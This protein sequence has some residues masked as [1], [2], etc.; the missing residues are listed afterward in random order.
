MLTKRGK[1]PKIARYCA[2]ISSSWVNGQWHMTHV[3]H[4]K[5]VTHD[6]LAHSISVVQ[7]SQGRLALRAIVIVQWQPQCRTRAICNLFLNLSIS[8]PKAKDTDQEMAPVRPWCFVQS[9][10]NPM[11]CG[12]AENYFSIL[13]ACMSLFSYLQ[14]QFRCLMCLHRLGRLKSVY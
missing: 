6:P 4:P 3:T 13:H 9:W 11:Y 1:E 2:V 10:I 5:M 12:T 7:G 8:A 14:K